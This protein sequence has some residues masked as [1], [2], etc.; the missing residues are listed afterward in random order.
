MYFHNIRT[1]EFKDQQNV[2]ICA[3]PM[4]DWYITVVG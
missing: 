3:N 4:K 2:L 1:L